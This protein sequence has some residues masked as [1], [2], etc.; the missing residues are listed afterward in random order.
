[1]QMGM[2]PPALAAFHF[3]SHTWPFQMRIE[4]WLGPAVLKAGFEPS[5]LDGNLRNFALTLWDQPGLSR[6]NRGG[7]HSRYLDISDA[8]D[9]GNATVLSELA[10][11]VQDVAALFLQKWTPPKSQCGERPEQAGFALQLFG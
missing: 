3:K 2:A 6:S 11:R 9:A 8:D 5:R 4:T 1:M 10:Q 7:W